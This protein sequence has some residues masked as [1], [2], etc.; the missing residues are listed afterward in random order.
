MI[1]ASTMPISTATNAMTA[2]LPLLA[3]IADETPS[4]SENL[5]GR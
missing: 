5:L 4:K 1:T 2:G 3:E